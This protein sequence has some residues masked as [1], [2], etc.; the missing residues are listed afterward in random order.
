[1]MLSWIFFL[2]NPNE[3]PLMTFDEIAYR[4]M[5]DYEAMGNFVNE[6]SRTFGDGIPGKLYHQRMVNFRRAKDLRNGGFFQVP[7]THIK[8]KQY[9]SHVLA[10]RLVNKMRFFISTIMTLQAIIM[11]CVAG[12]HLW[13]IWC[14]IEVD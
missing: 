10:L 12:F 2:N 14:W 3:D 9:H 1:M 4:S 13:L 7:K 11:A 6:L 8:R 5:I